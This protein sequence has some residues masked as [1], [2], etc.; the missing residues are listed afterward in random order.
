MAI[1]L[2]LEGDESAIA[3]LHG[4]LVLV[5]EDQGF[6]QEHHGNGAN[7]EPVAFNELF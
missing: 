4:L 2:L 1:L 3:R 6:R 5:K 7:R